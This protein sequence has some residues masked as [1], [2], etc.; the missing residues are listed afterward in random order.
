MDQATSNTPNSNTGNPTGGT[1]SHGTAVA[2]RLPILFWIPLISSPR[3]A[4]GTFHSNQGL[5]HLLTWIAGNII[6]MFIPFLGWV[7]LPVWFI[8]NV[9]LMIMGMIDASKGGMKPLPVVGHI[10]LIK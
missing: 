7:L 10:T 8:L 6:L 1:A 4:V 3:T 9:A 2:A 5:V